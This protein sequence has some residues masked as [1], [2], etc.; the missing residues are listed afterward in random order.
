LPVS[1]FLVKKAEELVQIP[2]SKGLRM[3]FGSSPTWTTSAKSLNIND[4]Y[5][6]EKKKEQH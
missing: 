4:A 1:G 2:S 6:G 3:L 5:K